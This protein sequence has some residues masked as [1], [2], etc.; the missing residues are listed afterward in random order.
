[1]DNYEEHYQSSLQ[2][3]ILMMES[4]E[5]LE[6]TSAL[7]QAASDR[8]IPEGEELGKFVRWANAQLFGD[9]A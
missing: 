1:M 2:E 5:G 8:G 7:K 6:P 9:N 3:A 4:C